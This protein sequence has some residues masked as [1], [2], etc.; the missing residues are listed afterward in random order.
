MEPIFRKQGV[1]QCELVRL[2][3]QQAQRTI[4]ASKEAHHRFMVLAR[5]PPKSQ[6][7]QR[8]FLERP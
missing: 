8:C 3:I 7:V 6:D 4:V 2:A 1:G 5:N